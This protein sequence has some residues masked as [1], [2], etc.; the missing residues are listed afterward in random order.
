VLGAPRAPN[1]YQC[2]AHGEQSGA[3]ARGAFFLA[4][5]HRV[6]RVGHAAARI[7]KASAIDASRLPSPMRIGREPGS[8]G[9]QSSDHNVLFQP[10]QIVLQAAHRRFFE[11]IKALP[12]SEQKAPTAAHER[13]RRIDALYDIEREAKGLSDTE[14]T[15]LRQ[16]NTTRMG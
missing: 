3:L 6:L 9:D 2:K 12:K 13:V 11:A 10:A 7:H 16:Q 1:T 5:A 14:R 15:A 4:N 8:G